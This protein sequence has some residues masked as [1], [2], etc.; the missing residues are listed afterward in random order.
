MS[1]VIGK[2]KTTVR[3]HYISIITAKKYLNTDIPSTSDDTE[4]LDI[5][6]ITNENAK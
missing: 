4:K 3:Y 5:P 1:L 2:Y 6:Y